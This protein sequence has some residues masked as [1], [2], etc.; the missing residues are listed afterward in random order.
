VLDECGVGHLIPTLPVLNGPD[1]VRQAHDVVARFFREGRL[2]ADAGAALLGLLAALDGLTSSEVVLEDICTDIVTAIR[3][4]DE[5]MAESRSTT[6]EKMQTLEV[7]GLLAEID[8]G[9]K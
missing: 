7:S 5:Q 1:T 8:E 4:G 3:S 2:G 6:E 9:R